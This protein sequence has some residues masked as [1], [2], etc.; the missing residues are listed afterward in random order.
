MGSTVLRRASDAFVPVRDGA[1]AG[2]I[3][4]RAALLIPLI[5]KDGIWLSVTG[6]Q[7]V[8]LILL[9]PIVLLAATVTGKRGIR[10]PVT[11]DS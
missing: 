4:G 6:N 3:E 7:V 11:D 8:G 5:G 9:I 2:Y 1:V 10:L